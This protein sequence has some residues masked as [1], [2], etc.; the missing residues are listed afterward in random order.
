MFIEMSFDLS[1]TMTALQL[2]NT[3]FSDLKMIIVQGPAVIM[4]NN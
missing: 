3:I 4:E 2:N 1:S